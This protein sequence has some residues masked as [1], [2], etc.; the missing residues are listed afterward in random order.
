MGV[1]EFFFY[2][3]GLEMMLPAVLYSANVEE[4][5]MHRL[6]AEDLLVLV[7]GYPE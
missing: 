1:V 3:P 2:L 5:L 7:S 4:R 6:N